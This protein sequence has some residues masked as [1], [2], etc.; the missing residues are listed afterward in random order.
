MNRIV[1][2][3]AMMSN[4]PY[5]AKMKNLFGASLIAYWP[6]NE[7][8]GLT[9]L[10][11][12]GYGANG[13]Y[14]NTGVTYA[15]PGF[16]GSDKAALFDGAAGRINIYSSYLAGALN[17]QECSILTW[18]KPT[19]SIW[20][21][22]ASYKNIWGLLADVS[23]SISLNTGGQSNRIT[24]SYRANGV[25]T[26]VT[27][28]G[29]YDISFLPVAITVSYSNSRARLYLNGNL[30]GNQAVS[31]AF[32][33][34]IAS[35][36]AWYASDNGGV[37]YGNFTGQHMVIVNREITPAEVSTFSQ[38]VFNTLGN[39]FLVDFGD[40]RVTSR[41]WQH[42]LTNSLDSSPG[43]VWKDIMLGTSGS[44]TVTWQ[45]A[46]DASLATAYGTP[47]YILF[48]LGVN[49]ATG[50]TG[51][52][53]FKADYLYILDAFHAKWPNAKIYCAHFWKRSNDAVCTTYNGYVDYCIGQRSSFCFAGLDE[54]TTLKGSD[55]GNTNT[56]DG[57]HY[58]TA[59]CTA[60]AAAWQTAM[61][62]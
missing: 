42:L 28:T 29:F 31:N 23:N 35:S 61:G 56:T 1:K 18:I 16:L 54:P 22:G 53:T 49:D 6:L 27:T 41:G 24:L 30:F 7:S 20:N 2:I 52:A 38:Q 21:T 25:A 46:I 4:I 13:A 48:N 8:V 51:E 9:A 55:N 45:A 5:W 14:R 37:G 12:S 11:I 34:S 15:Q 62:M 19:D 32:A 3:A 10:D 44:T 26:T 39:Q 58:S 57:L 40:S 17:G 59:G 43:R 50:G 36:H 33:G 60:V 47:G